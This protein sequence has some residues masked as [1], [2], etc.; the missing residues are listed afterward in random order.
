MKRTLAVAAALALAP[1]AA[2]AQG[3]I[4]IKAGLTYSNVN[5]SGVAPGTSL[6]GNNGWTAGLSFGT[7]SDS[8]PIG[9]RIE[10]LYARRGVNSSSTGD[11]RRF[12]FIDVPVML[13]VKLPIPA[14]SP[15][16]YAGPQLSYQVRCATDNGTC[17][18]YGDNG[19]SYAADVGAGLRLGGSSAV[20][21]EGR[22]MYGLTDFTWGTVS[23]SSSYRTRQFL[24]LAGIGF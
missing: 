2:F 16:A 21:I 5:Q 15:Y 18:S 24:L 7:A 4:G 13:E 20:T 14:V 1:A 9:L 12:D 17:P 10:G 8:T 23:S 3:G 6:S 11:S 19:W 22:Y